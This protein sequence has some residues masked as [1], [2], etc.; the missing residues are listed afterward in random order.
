MILRRVAVLFKG[1]EEAAFG[2]VCQ[3]RQGCDD[4]MRGEWGL[5]LTEEVLLGRVVYT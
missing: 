2:N 4:C 5:S 3:A 1:F